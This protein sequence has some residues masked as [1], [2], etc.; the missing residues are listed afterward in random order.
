MR[1]EDYVAAGYFVSRWTGARDCTGTELRRV[2][3][4]SDHSQRSFFPDSW[5][6]S[7]CDDTRESR[8]ERASIF[9]ISEDQLDEVM[10]WADAG[11]DREFGAWS[12]FFT[13]KAA[14]DAARLVLPNARGLEIWGLGIHRT[15]LRSF[16]E[17]SE[18]P[19]SPPGAAPIGASGAHVVACI[20]SAPLVEGGEVLG[21]EILINEAGSCF[22]SP[23]SRHLDEQAVCRAV[24]VV[25]NNDGL[26]DSF[27]AAYSC[28]RELDA[29]AG[30]TQHGI[31]GWMPWLVVRYPWP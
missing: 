8:V 29:H 18:P 31:R 11:F 22:N 24:G 6:L 14:Q 12:V 16:S 1:I 10:R 28:C 23:E 20:R 15:L 17:A 30:E 5:A 2:T 4:A 27:E 9:G 25:P 7:W 3:L 19:Q 13:L 26:I 21:H